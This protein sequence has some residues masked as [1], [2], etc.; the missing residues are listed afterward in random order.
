MEPES[1]YANRK[2][3]AIHLHGAREDLCYWGGVGNTLLSKTKEYNP[4]TDRWTKKADMPTRREGFSTS[5]VADTIYA[6]GGR[7][8]GGMLAVVEAYD[9]ATNTWEKAPNVPTPRGNL[10][11]NTVQ[12]KVYAIGGSQGLLRRALAT[13]EAYDTE[14][15]PQSIQPREKL[16]TIWGQ[17]KVER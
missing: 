13:M 1:G 14:L 7:N 11:T 12:G 15:L 5:S 8:L 10:S 6:I 4:L 9:P 17:L 16:A 3:C 2:I